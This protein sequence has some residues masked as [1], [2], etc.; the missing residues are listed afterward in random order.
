MFFFD[1]MVFVG[2]GIECYELFFVFVGKF[3]EYVVVENGRIYVEGVFWLF[4]DLVRLLIVGGVCW[5]ECE[6]FVIDIVEEN[7]VFEE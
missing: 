4:L 3:D 5:V 6:S 7:E 1:I 2:F